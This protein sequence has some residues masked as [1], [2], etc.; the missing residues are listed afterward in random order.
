MCPLEGTLCIENKSSYI[1]YQ[2]KPDSLHNVT[3]KNQA[4]WQKDKL[5]YKKAIK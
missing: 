3:L 4:I 1:G 2:I 5:Q